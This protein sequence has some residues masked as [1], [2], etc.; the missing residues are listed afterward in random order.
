MKKHDLILALGFLLFSYQNYG[1]DIG[2]SAVNEIDNTVRKEMKISQAPGAVIGVVKNENIIFQKAY[3]ILNSKTNKPATTSTLFLI[4]SLTKTFTTTALLMVCEENNIDLHAPIGNIL[5]DL[6]PKLSH[7]TIHGILSQSS[8]LLDHWPTRKKFKNSAEAYFLH[9]GDKLVNDDLDSV[10]SYTNFGHVMAGRILESLTKKT[11][12]DV[13]NQLILEPLDMSHSTFNVDTAKTASFSTGHINK[14][15][16]SHKLT[17]PLIQPSASLFSNIEDLSHFAICFMNGGVYN[18]EQVIS[19]E[20]IRKMST[21]NTFIGLIPE[22]FG[23]P[24]SFYNYG[25]ISFT[26]KGISF[27]GHPGESASQN[28]LFAMA[29]A[30]QTAII[31]LS[32]TGYYPFRATFEILADTFNPVQ[33]EPIANNTVSDEL[34]EFEGK[35]YTPNIYGSTDEVIEIYVKNKIL[36]IRFYEEEYYPLEKIGK[37]RFMYERSNIKFPLEIIFYQDKNGNIKYLNNFWK[38]SIKR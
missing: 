31:V 4:A 9:Y 10:F 22:Y 20:V 34:Q 23:Y 36:Y 29:P 16:V 18:D 37:S 28:T 35:Y 26:Y 17:Y 6:S 7:L 12:T 33:N 8:G 3:G 19:K 24:D 1:Q 13:I 38:I 25:L 2:Q 14:K 11:Y 30:N 27:L 15:S 5:V 32:N 21:K